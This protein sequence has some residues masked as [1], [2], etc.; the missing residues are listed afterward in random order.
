MKKSLLKYPLAT[1][2]PWLTA[3]ICALI[4]YYLATYEV[5]LVD[6]LYQALCVRHYRLAPLAPLTYY[7]GHIWTAIFGQGIY[8]LRVLA[9]LLYELAIAV[10]TIYAWHHGISKRAALFM[11]GIL[12]LCINPINYY[13]DGLNIYNWDT[14]CYLPVTM[15]MLALTSYVR[16]P[17]SLTIALTGLLTACAICCRFTCVAI[18]P[19]CMA[20]IFIY[21]GSGKRMLKD[22]VIYLAT[23]TALCI[24]ILIVIFGSIDAYIYTFKQGVITGHGFMEVI[25]DSIKCIDGVAYFWI[26]GLILLPFAFVR[27]KVVRLTSI[28]LALVVFV[29][30]YKYRTVGFGYMQLPFY[31]LTIWCIIRTSGQDRVIS[32]ILLIFSLIPGLGSDAYPYRPFFLPMIPLLYRIITTNNIRKAIEYFNMAAIFCIIIA[33]MF[34]VKTST[35]IAKAVP[36]R[37]PHMEHIVEQKEGAAYINDLYTPSPGSNLVAVGTH[38]YLYDYA[39]TDRPG[40]KLHL[41]HYKTL[42][43]QDIKTDAGYVASMTDTVLITPFTGNY[44][45]ELT[46]EYLAELYRL[47]F[48]TADS[49]DTHI[50]KTR[51]T[52]KTTQ[53]LLK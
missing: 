52:T 4:P 30:L 47:G 45:N 10:G 33:V 11:F 36:I 27:K 28:L 20:I 8:T 25:T 6:E 23:T 18:L 13:S 39:Y 42:D 19:V 46:A 53:T 15:T 5:N 51:L 35:I 38:K 22:T 41:F 43:L 34:C 26:P 29:I 9:L 21:G 50:L 24:V 40:Y 17:S 49:T 7:T 44:A 2:L 3:V 32:I 48:Q 1:L 12:C 37:H 16:K 31:I 14:G